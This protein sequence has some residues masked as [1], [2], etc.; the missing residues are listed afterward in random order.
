MGN[1]KTFLEGKK[2][3]ILALGAIVT[4]LGAYASGSIDT[5][6]LI[7]SIWA[8]LTGITLRAGVAKAE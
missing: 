6:T 7:Q 1:I 2:T 8:A 3:Y 4:A 5:V